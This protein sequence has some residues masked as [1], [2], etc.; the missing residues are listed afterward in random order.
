MTHGTDIP[1]T[2]RGRLN[3]W[4]L[5][6]VGLWLLVALS[7]ASAAQSIAW[8]L[9]T[10]AVNNNWTS[11]TYGNGLFVAVAET[12]T[13]N[14]V[15]TSPDGIN[16]TART[17]AADNQ[18]MSV[19]YGNGLFVAVAMTGTDQVMTSPNGIDWTAR[20]TGLSAGWRSITYG[21]GLFVAVS[22]G[23][24]SNCAATTASQVITSPDGITW[25]PTPSPHSS[26][27]TVTHGY[28][29][30]GKDL[31]VAV[32]CAASGACALS[33]TIMT[34]PDGSNWT[35]LATGVSSGWRSIT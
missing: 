28:D 22:C 26:W 23:A 30:A 7:P 10:S 6:F 21:K 3:R 9:R 8:T 31:F 18:W 35:S 24:D 19:T 33:S 4:L 17:S 13:G 27:V 29:P 32:A 20:N 1:L 2:R 16:W 15:M 5:G 34:S 14:R 11:V 12:G 25:T